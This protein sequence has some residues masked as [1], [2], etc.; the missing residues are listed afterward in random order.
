MITWQRWDDSVRVLK[1]KGAHAMSK[2]KR[3][4][5]VYCRNCGVIS[6][7]NEQSKKALRKECEWLEDG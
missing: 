1:K 4:S 3:H 6:L 2:M 5:W 7:K